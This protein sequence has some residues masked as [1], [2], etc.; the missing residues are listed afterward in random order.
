MIYVVEIESPS[1]ARASKEYD[2]PTM[3][4]AWRAMERDLLHYPKI[5]VIDIRE[6][7]GPEISISEEAW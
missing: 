4:T 2:A 5:R 1:G 3:M 6:K 7:D